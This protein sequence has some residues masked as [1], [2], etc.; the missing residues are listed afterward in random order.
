MMGAS[1]AEN[2]AQSLGAFS[3]QPL[4]GCK[5]LVT[6]MCREV[7]GCSVSLSVN[8]PLS[9]MENPQPKCSALTLRTSQNQGLWTWP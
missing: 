6:Q 7:A 4:K 8:P 9:E 2:K 3:W 5:V 1:Q